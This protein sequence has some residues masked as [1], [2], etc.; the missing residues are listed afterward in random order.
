MRLIDADAEIKAIKETIR[1]KERQLKR[2]LE[3]K[4]KE[5]NNAYVDF[6]KKIADKKKYISD[7]K[8][9]IRILESCKTVD[10]CKKC[11]AKQK[12]RLGIKYMSV[13]QYVKNAAEKKGAVTDDK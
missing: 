6:D 3:L 10:L 4:G 1:R 8:H 5:P 12:E 13:S 2:L 7:C 9:E 11:T